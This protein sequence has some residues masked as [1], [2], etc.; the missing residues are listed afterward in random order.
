M[1][2]RVADLAPWFTSVP[3]GSSSPTNRGIAERAGIMLG[4]EVN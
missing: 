3:D 2:G 1:D 4:D